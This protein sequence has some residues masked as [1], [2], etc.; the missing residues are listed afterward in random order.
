MLRLMNAQVTCRLNWALNNVA[1]LKEAVIKGEA[2]FGT[3]DTWLM[4]KVK[5]VKYELKSAL[6]GRRIFHIS[7]KEEI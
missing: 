6:L 4:Y 3:V 5:Y 2:A 1:A 7:H